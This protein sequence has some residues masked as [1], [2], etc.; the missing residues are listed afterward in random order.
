MMQR[1]M[2]DGVAAAPPRASPDKWM[3]YLAENLL[4]DLEDTPQVPSS[5]LCAGTRELGGSED[6][7]EKKF[8]KRCARDDL[9]HAAPASHGPR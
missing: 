9:V 2:S 6:G 1:G 3:S 7:G 8:G 4:L 5:F